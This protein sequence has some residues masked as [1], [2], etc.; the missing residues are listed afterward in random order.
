MPAF[1]HLAWTDDVA[2]TAWLG[3][4][5]GDGPPAA[6]TDL[7]PPGFE[8]YVR[9]LHPAADPAPGGRRLVRW[10][11][12]AAWSGRPLASHSPFHAVAMP[13]HDVSGAPPWSGDGPRRGSLAAPDASVLMAAVRRHTRTPDTC[14]FG[15]WDGY[16][17]AGSSSAAETSAR[18][19]LATAPSSVE[20]I[21]RRY[22]LYRGPVECAFIRMYG[23]EHQ[24][25]NV[26]WPE[27]RAWFVA[28][29]VDLS[30]TYV[31]GSVALTRALIGDPGLEAFE[32]A[33][34]DPVAAV[35]PRIAELARPAVDSLFDE[36]YGSVE[37]PIG[38]VDARL[39]L[40]RWLGQGTLAYTTRSRTGA[41]GG[42]TL[43]L[44]RRQRSGAVLRETI[45]QY[46]QE[47]VIGLVGG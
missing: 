38:S 39:R 32:V 2:A 6:V 12:V 14:W 5:P 46:L 3:E 22:R 42:G 28:S 17:R 18:N 21:G 44:S 25:A 27:D 7:V 15:L 13:D 24:T 31:G 29:E 47:A 37:T 41:H 36:G 4:Q 8:A 19:R 26:W 23:S 33:P 30:C 16:G 10:R 11:D 43:V 35:E 9:V 1:E 40:P 20:L 45:A 34:D